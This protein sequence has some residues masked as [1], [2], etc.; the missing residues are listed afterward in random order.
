MSLPFPLLRHPFFLQF[1]RQF[2]AFSGLGVGMGIAVTVALTNFPAQAEMSRAD[3]ESIVRDYLNNNPQVIINSVE[4]FRAQ[5]ENS[6]RLATLAANRDKLDGDSRVPVAGNPQGDV[7]VVEFFDYQCGYC[8]HVRKE[9]LALLEQDRNVRF[10]LKEFP[11]L[12]PLSTAAARAALAARRQNKYWEMHNA[13]M[14]YRG[15]LTEAAIPDIARG[16]GL[17]PARLEKDMKDTE[18][19]TI[20]EDARALGESLGL[21]GT[22]AFVIGSQVAPGAIDLQSMKKWVAQARE[23]RS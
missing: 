20:L 17:D 19:D 2:L 4:K 16:I 6:Q 9:V 15:R 10:V 21:T 11:I 7:T 1:S 5:Q 14:G 23:N 8:K 13:L 18:I 22:P 3:V 12:G